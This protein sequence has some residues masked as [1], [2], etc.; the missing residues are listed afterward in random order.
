MMMPEPS[1][2]TA[3][4]AGERK[5]LWE[6][7]HWQRFCLWLSSWLLR[8]ESRQGPN[9]FADYGWQGKDNKERRELLQFSLQDPGVTVGER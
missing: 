7:R 9:Y 2:G 6:G 3:F 5:L 1:A 8:R 4:L